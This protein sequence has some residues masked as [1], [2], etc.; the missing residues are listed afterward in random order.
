MRKQLR[1]WRASVGAQENTPNPAVDQNLYRQLYV[2]FDP[3]RFDPLRADDAAWTA[4]GIWRERM[5][6]A[7]KRAPR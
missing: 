7:V 5:D 1:S 3:T 6:A 4:V 2:D